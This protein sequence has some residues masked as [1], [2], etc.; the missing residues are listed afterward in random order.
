VC[1]SVGA[2]GEGK[3]LTVREKRREGRERLVDHRNERLS[4][5]VLLIACCCYCFL[6]QVEEDIDDRPS[7]GGAA[8]L[9][10]RLAGLS[11]F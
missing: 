5:F 4:V 11:A 10:K 8:V 9:G 1:E 3:V 6:W 2:C 7:G